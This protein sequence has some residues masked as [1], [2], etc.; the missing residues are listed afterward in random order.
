MTMRFHLPPGG[1][2]SPAAAARRLGL[3]LPE[4]ELALP[5][6]QARTPPFPAPDPTTGNYDLDAIEK[7]RQARFPQ[8]FPA[9]S[10]TSSPAA[11]DAR[12][13]V[14]PRLARLQRG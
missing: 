10:L 7:W 14:G 12:D 2:I 5:K 13:V 11:R 4:F 9:T 3:S 6:L 8:L 1:D